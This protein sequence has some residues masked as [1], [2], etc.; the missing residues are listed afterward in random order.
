MTYFEFLL[1]FLAIPIILLVAMRPWKTGSSN[2]LWLAIGAQ[3]LLALIYTTP[4]DNHLVATGVWYYN[5]KLVTGY[6][7]GYVPIEEYTF[8]VLETLLAGLWWQ[9]CSARLGRPDRFRPSR[10]GEWGPQA[11]WQFY[12][13]C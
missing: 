11:A 4:W 12:G 6:V 3:V 5:P 7:L 8:F 2:W 9:L 10:V 13:A 1:L